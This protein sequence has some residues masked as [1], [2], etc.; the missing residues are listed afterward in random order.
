MKIKR[1]K[2]FTGLIAILVLVLAISIFVLIQG[3]N[4][5]AGSVGSASET[6]KQEVANQ[7]Q[8]NDNNSSLP[9]EL[10]KNLPNEVSAISLAPINGQSGS[11]TVVAVVDGENLALAF[12]ATLPDSGNNSYFAWLAKDTEGKNLQIIGKLEKKEGKYLLP[13]TVKGPLANYQKLVITIE[14]I[15]DDKPERVVLEGKIRSK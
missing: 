15:Q 1:N 13:A 6:S 9:A 5:S 3:K 11:A 14:S 7:E 12:E 2:I 8:N 10:V 4:K